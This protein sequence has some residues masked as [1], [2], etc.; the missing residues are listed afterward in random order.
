MAKRKQWPDPMGSY[1]PGVVYR[2]GYWGNLVRVL[3]VRR[4]PGWGDIWVTE[5]S[6]DGPNTGIVRS[7]GTPWS[8]RDRVVSS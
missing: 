1:A 4:G 7:H 2:D 8:R 3:E 5:V 6:L